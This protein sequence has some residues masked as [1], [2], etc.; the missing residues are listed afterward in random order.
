MEK[1][2]G[3]TLCIHHSKYIDGFCRE[4][5]L[6]NLIWMWQLCKT[7][8]RT[9][10]HDSMP[11]N[12]IIRCQQSAYWLFPSGSPNK[13]NHKYIYIYAYIHMKHTHIYIYTYT[14]M[15]HLCQPGTKRTCIRDTFEYVLR[16]SEVTCT[17]L[18]RWNSVVEGQKVILLKPKFHKGLQSERYTSFITHNPS[19]VGFLTYLSYVFP[20]LNSFFEVSLSWIPQKL[21]HTFQ[22]FSRYHCRNT[23]Q[24]FLPEIEI[25]NGTVLQDV[26]ILEL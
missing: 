24:F 23:P 7:N 14:H 15:R 5:D 26:T 3:Q 22:E 2:S 8:R 4:H 25:V 19:H 17:C 16:G 12:E 10:K 18:K 1:N 21:G 20:V 6:R 13:W 9:I 11:F